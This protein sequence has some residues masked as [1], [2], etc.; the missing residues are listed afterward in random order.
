MVIGDI[1]QDA[2]ALLH[3][4]QRVAIEVDPDHRNRDLALQ[5]GKCVGVPAVEF[6]HAG[7]T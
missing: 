6:Y 4:G 3:Q 5:P 2:N 7:N 1:V